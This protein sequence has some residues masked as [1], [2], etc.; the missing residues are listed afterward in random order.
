MKNKILLVAI[1]ARYTH[2]NLAIRYLRN[3]VSDLNYICE[4]KEFTINQ[5]PLNILK[6]IY[7]SKPDIIAFSVYIWNTEISKILL[8]EIKKVLP[9][10]KIIIG[11]PEVSYNSLKWLTAFDSVDWIICGHG[12]EGFRYLLK[13]NLKISEK[14]ININNPAFKQLP[15]PYLESDFPTLQNKYIYYESSRGCPYKCSYCLSSRSDQKLEYKEIERVKEELIWLIDKQPKIIKFVDRTFNADRHFSRI[16]WRLLINLHPKTKFHFEIHP[17][18]LEDADFDLL[19]SAPSDLFQFEIGIQSTNPKTITAINRQQ[20]WSISKKNIKKLLKL[21]KFHVHVDLI[22]GLP[23][24]DMISF[25]QSFNEIISLNADHFQM[26]FL[27]VLPGTNMADNI[28]K[29]ALRFSDKAPY[30]IL[31]NR[32]L[33][34]DDTIKLHI[35]EH[36]VDSIYNSSKFKTTYRSIITLFPDPYTMFNSIAD[37]LNDLNHEDIEKGWERTGR[38]LLDYIKI[39]FPQ[40]S[41]MIFDSLCWDWCGIAGSHFFPPFLRSDQSSKWKK[42]GISF[43]HEYKIADIIELEGNQYSW[44]SIKKAIFYQPRSQK[45]CRLFKLEQSIYTFIPNEMQKIVIPLS[46]QL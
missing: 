37:Y 2:S 40:F 9:D 36:L 46:I 12:E 8:A 34:F 32:W 4:L 43:L 23:Y 21:Q 39:Y 18:L 15:F 5:Y 6:N 28:E 25:Q 16:I 29:F 10:V 38:M 45:F 14:I 31:S 27:K 11:G 1:N 3:Y 19:N 26:G 13:N 35:I 17:A 24:E 44:K 41:D 7:L 30:Q 22:A 42:N 33:S 20:N